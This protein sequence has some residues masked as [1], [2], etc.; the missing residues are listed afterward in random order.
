MTTATGSREDVI[1]LLRQVSLFATLSDDLLNTVARACEPVRLDAGNWLFRQGQ[2]EDGL[3]IL[4][5]GRLEIVMESATGA[6]A[7]V[8]DLRPGEPV[9]ELALL[10]SGTRQASV[11]ALRHS[12][13]WRIERRH[14]NELLAASPSFAHALLSVLAEKVSVAPA[15]PQ[16]RRLPRVIGSVALQPGLAVRETVGELERTLTRYGRVAVLEAPEAHVG[17]NPEGTWKTTHM[18]FRF[19]PEA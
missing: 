13:L 1:A 7:I 19:R 18:R 14:F 2:P 5:S 17:D 16:K 3:Y 8:R 11:R 15:P 10:R 4:A 9:G 12:E 6:E